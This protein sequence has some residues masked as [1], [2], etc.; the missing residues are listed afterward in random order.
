[1][2]NIDYLICFKTDITKLRLIHA[3]YMYRIG[4]RLVVKMISQFKQKL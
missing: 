1:M 3:N 2:G 4:I